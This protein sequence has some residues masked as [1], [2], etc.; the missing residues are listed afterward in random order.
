MPDSGIAR[1]LPRNLLDRSLGDT[2]AFRNS[3]PAP[4]PFL[5][6]IEDKLMERFVHADSIDP[7]IGPVKPALEFCAEVACF[8]MS[9]A[10]RKPKTP[11]ELRAVIARRV[12]VAMRSEFKAE[13][14][15]PKALANR[16]GVSLSTIQRILEGQNGPSVDTV[17]VIADALNVAV[18]ALLGQWSQ[19]DQMPDDGLPTSAGVRT[20]PTDRMVAQEQ[21]ES[22]RQVYRFLPAADRVAI[23]AL[24][25]SGR[26]RMVEMAHQHM[27]SIAGGGDKKSEDHGGNH[28]SRGKK[29]MR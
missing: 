25:D 26:Q 2:G 1:L 22:L 9:G 16:A 5:K 12:G 27:D 3:G 4:L 13:A 6:V 23:Q 15:K 24:I 18:D 19:F 11:G 7:K 28:D 17:E 10:P 21:A 20:P 29:T 14:N 8:P